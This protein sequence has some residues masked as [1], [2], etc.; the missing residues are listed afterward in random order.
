MPQCPRDHR[1]REPPGC[2]GRLERGINLVAVAMIPDD[3]NHVRTSDERI[4]SNVADFAISANRAHL[5]LV[6]DEQSVEMYL[7]SEYTS[8]Y[9]M[10]KG[11]R[12]R[13]RFGDLWKRN[14]RRHYRR[15]LRGD[16]RPKRY[17]LPRTQVDEA[18]F[19]RRQFVVRIARRAA[20]AG[21]M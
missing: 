21:E 18:R 4:D 6:R 10:R 5:Q 20:H 7:V 16:R 2:V 8:Q 13:R 17:Q 14:V 1:M 3:H 11:R 12:Q 19:E 9:A 15:D